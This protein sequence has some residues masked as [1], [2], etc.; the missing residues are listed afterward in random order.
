M[1]DEMKE[2]ETIA[3]R[4]RKNCLLTPEELASQCVSPKLQFE[5][6][7]NQNER[8]GMKSQAFRGRQANDLG[9]A[10]LITNSDLQPETT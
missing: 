10:G 4:P 7:W 6:R 8:V 5:G 9:A 2:L 3:D 1:D